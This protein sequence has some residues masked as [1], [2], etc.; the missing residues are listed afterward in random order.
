MVSATGKARG[1]LLVVTNLKTVPCI[2]KHCNV[3]ETTTMTASMQHLQ[4]AKSG[5]PLEMHHAK[6]SYL[7]LTPCITAHSVGA[8]SVAG[9]RTHLRDCCWRL[10]QLLSLMLRKLHGSMGHVAKDISESISDFLGLDHHQR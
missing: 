8:P 10:A 3:A 5:L 6:Q 7:S 4:T 9:Q 1:A 2:V